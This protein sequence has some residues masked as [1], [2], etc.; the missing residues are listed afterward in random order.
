MNA[1]LHWNPKETKTEWNNGPIR[2]SPLLFICLM[3]DMEMW[4]EK[5][6]LANFADDTQSII[7][8][9]NLEEALENTT[10]EANN[11]INFF[12]C[13]NLVNNAEKAAV[14]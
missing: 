9:D 6:M 2:L 4:T 12:S 1:S 13:N 7:I 3:A 5:G 8:E 11:V 14:L 10:I